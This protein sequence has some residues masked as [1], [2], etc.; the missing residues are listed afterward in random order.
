[1][2]LLTSRVR[3]NVNMKIEPHTQNNDSEHNIFIKSCTTQVKTKVHGY[4]HLSPSH[5]L[6]TSA[7][8]QSKPQA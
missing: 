4:I 3:E 1:M 5:L 2:T 7:R 8:L 6:T